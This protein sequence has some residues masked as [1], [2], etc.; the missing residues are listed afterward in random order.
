MFLR[1]FMLSTTILLFSACSVKDGEL[2]RHISFE[3]FYKERQIEPKKALYENAFKNLRTMLY[4][5][6][7]RKLKMSTF[8]LLVPLISNYK[9]GTPHQPDIS[10]FIKKPLILYLSDIYT[11]Y[12]L[13]SR[14]FQP[15]KQQT[16]SQSSPLTKINFVIT[17]SVSKYQKE[18][19]TYQQN[20][21]A[22]FSLGLRESDLDGDG[23]YRSMKSISEHLIN[24]SLF[25]ED[26]WSNSFVASAENTTKVY[27][28]KNKAN[29]GIYFGMSMLNLGG[30]R[31]ES[32]QMQQSMDEAI[33]TL[34]QFTFIQLLGRLEALP[35]WRCFT[36]NLEP[37]SIV[38]DILVNSYNKNYKVEIKWLMQKFYGVDGI[39]LRKA[40]LSNGEKR[41]WDLIIK[42][43]KLP[44]FDYK[45]PYSKENIKTYLYLHE[46]A[47]IL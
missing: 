34:A 14:G 1:I 44:K 46:H 47:P 16:L 23:D 27:V 6:N 7:R 28:L 20:Y 32:L 42:N 43:N 35:Y 38:I 21:D 40:G 45:N 19:A 8:G 3:N 5:V 2:D 9:T 18:M 36:P 30:G 29:S 22:D 39:D 41:V 33:E 12:N 10:S 13:D 15:Y 4:A 17:G 26:G 25:L 24:I 37:D 31:S 11:L